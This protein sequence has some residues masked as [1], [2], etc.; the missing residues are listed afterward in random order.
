MRQVESVHETH[1]SVVNRIWHVHG[2]RVTLHVIALASVI[3]ISLDP[4]RRLVAAV[5]T[6]VAALGTPHPLMP[7]CAF[8]G[9]IS[10]LMRTD[11]QG[12]RATILGTIRMLAFL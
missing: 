1:L 7:C 2:L 9:Q 4:V 11:V 12:L 3:A 5:C 8:N 6:A 10:S